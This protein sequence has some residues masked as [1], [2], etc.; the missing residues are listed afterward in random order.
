MTWAYLERH[1]IQLDARGSSIYAKNPRFSIFGIGDYAFYPWK[2]A[3][4]GLYKT[5]RFRLVGPIDGRP[6]MFDDTVYYLSFD[7]EA[8]AA[9]T[10]VMIESEPA[11][12]LLSSL[13]FWD[14]KR[15]VKTSI[16]NILDWSKL[17][18]TMSRQP[19]LF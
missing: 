7:T 5:L 6:V 19:A 12:G 16:L 11:R 9:A 1:G 15:P 14:E 8:E 2:I 3:I 18:R 4:C 10:L 17:D 13:I